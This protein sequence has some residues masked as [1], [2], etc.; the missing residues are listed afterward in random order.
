MYDRFYVILSGSVAVL[1]AE[2]KKVMMS[3]MEFLSYLT[4]LKSLSE[5][6]ML[7]KCL[8]SNPHFISTDN[9]AEIH[10]IACK[11]LPTLFRKSSVI[12]SKNVA[13]SN[14]PPTLIELEGRSEPKA[15]LDIQNV[16]HF[17][18]TIKPDLKET[19]PKEDRKLFKIW[20]YSNV[21]SLTVGDYFGEK[22]MQY[23]N[24]KR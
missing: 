20:R 10:K 6:E 19:T 15:L 1:V 17:L 11:R 14:N 22:A 13:T 9:E 8:E 3:D 7:R 5:K 23:A 21:I 24:L 4:K 2:E 16:E 12:R 18:D